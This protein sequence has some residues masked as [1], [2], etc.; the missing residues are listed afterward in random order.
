MTA[1]GAKTHGGRIS[2]GKARE[3]GKALRSDG[4]PEMLEKMVALG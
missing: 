2:E 3:E 1:C 4:R